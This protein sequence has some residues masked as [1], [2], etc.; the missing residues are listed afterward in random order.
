MILRHLSFYQPRHSRVRAFINFAVNEQEI[1][2]SFL[3]LD[4]VLKGPESVSCFF[5]P[6]VVAK[7]KLPALILRIQISLPFITGIHDNKLPLH[8]F[9]ID[10]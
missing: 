10:L 9:Y 4:H 3:N 2:L 5:V 1:R 6:F 8:C 7:N